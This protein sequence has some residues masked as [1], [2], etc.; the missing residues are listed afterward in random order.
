MDHMPNEKQWLYAKAAK[1]QIVWVR[2]TL[3][4]MILTALGHPHGINSLEERDAAKTVDDT[5]TSK[6]VLLPVYRF[7]A[8]GVIIKIRC[9]FHDWCVRCWTPL[10]KEFPSYM[11]EGM[12]KGYFEGM[13]GEESP[14]EFSVCYREELYAII[15]WML[16]EG[17]K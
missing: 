2:D 1:N 4:Y 7:E 15:W 12:C 11:T 13:E 16:N 9:N 10:K 6:S 8:N 17:I 14:V 5:H 3:A